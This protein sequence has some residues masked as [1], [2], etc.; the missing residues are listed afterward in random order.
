MSDRDDARGGRSAGD[1]GFGAPADDG[2]SDVSSF[3]GRRRTKRAR[4]SLRVPV[5][6]VPRRS[7]ADDLRSTPSS[8]ELPLDD[9]PSPIVFG[10]P[11]REEVPAVV[12]APPAPRVP[13]EAAAFAQSA[14]RAP[15]PAPAPVAAAAVA[16]SRPASV[17]PPRPGSVIPPPAF[18]SAGDLGRSAPTAGP[19]QEPGTDR[20]RRPVS[21]PAI[22][23]P[24][25]PPPAM[26]ASAPV[27]APASAPAPSSQSASPSSAPSGKFPSVSSGSVLVGR[28]VR[29]SDPPPGKRTVKP[30]PEPSFVI[31]PSLREE[32]PLAASDTAVD[33]EIEPEITPAPEEQAPSRDSLEILPG[34]ELLADDDTATT[35]GNL[36]AP[37]GGL[38]SGEVTV[39]EED[40]EP[41]VTRSSAAPEDDVVDALSDDL[42]EEKIPSQPPEAKSEAH[43]HAP[44]P[45]PAAAAAHAEPAPE[46]PRKKRSRPWFEEFFNDDYLRTVRPPKPAQV[47]RQC[48]FIENSFGLQRGATIL[49]VGCGLGAHAVELAARGYL[50]V[51][52]DLSLPMLSR[53]ADEAQDRGQKIN[54]LH[55][56]MREMSFEGTFDA[57]LCWGTTFG[58]FDDDLNRKV[59]DRL[60]RAL[61]PMGLLLLDVVNRDHVI[62]SQPNL[63]WFEGDGC[64][65]MEETQFNNITSRLHVKRT[66]ILEDGRQRE[67]EY[68]VRLYALHELGQMLHH[69]GFR[70]AEVS[71]LEATPGVFFGGDSPRMIILAERR[72]PLSKKETSDLAAGSEPAGAPTL[73][74]DNGGEGP[75]SGSTAV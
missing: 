70:V 38:V 33:I 13:A 6:E 9:D 73:K 52:L 25:A 74:K 11:R 24:S 20:T 7:S 32:R 43:G 55:A 21:S 53:A 57:I 3:T 37:P 54:F 41:V 18:S 19:F 61:K 60:M 30:E 59:V 67:N 56:D 22:R 8:D 27:S 62:R 35:P 71:G 49:D 69:Q 2:D 75:P 39:D 51:G 29:I 31:D 68:S 65:C 26:T 50:V 36:K 1:P 64:V 28:T 16:P 40:D 15:A 23:P 47:S 45:P 66:V 12:P 46:A 17:P 58:Y 14:P 44:P 5:D 4:R 63:V 42:L 10:S 48:D 72:L 34:D